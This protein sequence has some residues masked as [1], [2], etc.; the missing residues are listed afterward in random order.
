MYSMA[1]KAKAKTKL[2]QKQKQSQKQIVN[3]NIQQA[4]RNA[5]R[6][7]RQPMK[8]GDRAA[9]TP[10][11]RTNEPSA[12]FYYNYQPYAA[13]NPPVAAPLPVEPVPMPVPLPVPLRRN[14]TS[15]QPVSFEPPSLA[16]ADSEK[17]L[18]MYR[19]AGAGR[20]SSRGSS[21]SS[22]VSNEEPMY[23]SDVRTGYKTEYESPEEAGYFS[24]NV[25]KPPMPSP[26]QQPPPI[27][28]PAPRSRRRGGELWY[29]DGE[30]KALK[31]GVPIPEGKYWDRRLGKFKKI[32]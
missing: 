20:G 8:T 22:V 1:K 23:N 6:R 28:I 24:R 9:V 4:L 31:D 21:S 5:I 29:W 7:R 32:R 10:I 19:G 3:V 25:S 30:E 16:S 11:F 27:A 14:L 12:P 18:R 15:Y 26:F 17:L 13:V 2:K